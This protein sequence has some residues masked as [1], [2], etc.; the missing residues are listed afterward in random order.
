MSKKLAEGVDALILD[1]KVG[2]GAFMKRQVDARRL[3]QMMV[4][5]RP[6]HGQEGAGADHRHEPAPRLRH[7]QRARDHGS[8]ADTAERRAG[9]SNQALARAGRP[10]DL[11][12]QEGRYPR[13]S[14]QLAEKHLVDGS[15]YRKLKEVVAAQGGN[16]Q[17]L[18]KFELLPNATGM[19]EITS[20]RAGYISRHRRRETS[21]PRPT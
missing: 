3:A 6:P 14:A 19:R 7:R 1:V 11:P 9:R 16:P 8:V 20:P 4:G 5:D 12:R 2:S 13:R 17:A 15:A 21:A 10:H 18:D